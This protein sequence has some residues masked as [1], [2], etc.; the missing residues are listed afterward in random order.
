ML[1][2]RNE[3]DL[4]GGTGQQQY[5]S[6]LRRDRR[7]MHEQRKLLS[8]LH[9]CRRLLPPINTARRAVTFDVVNHA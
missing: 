5:D 2:E 9:L 8:A 7:H 6:L 4:L 3:P 1:H